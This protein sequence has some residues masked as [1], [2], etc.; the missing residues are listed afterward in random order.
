MSESE[1]RPAPGPRA[2]ALQRGVHRLAGHTAVVVGVIDALLILLFGLL[3]TNHLFLSLI[4]F[5]NIGFNASQ[6]VLLAVAATFELAAAQIDISLGAI[7]VLSSIVGG[8]VIQRLGGTSAQIQA[9]E[10]PHL[11]R[12]LI[13]GVAA[14]V[15]IGAAFGLANGLIVTRL[16]R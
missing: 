15:A 4:S 2:A 13:C 1:R 11:A 3:S 8:E 16:R 10:Y 12:A 14:C 5:Q 9:G 7:L 6:I